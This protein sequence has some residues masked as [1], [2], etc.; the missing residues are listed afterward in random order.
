M[1]HG[2]VPDVELDRLYGE[3]DWGLAMMQMHDN[4]PRYNRFSFPCKFTM[5]LAS[6]LPLICL[7]HP[8]SGLM[9]LALKYKLG[10]MI[11]EP[12]PEKAAAALLAGLPR[13]EN[14]GGYRSEIVRCAETDFNAE[15]TRK[16]LY[17][18]F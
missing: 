3:C 7:G 9:E 2:F 16:R 1:E 11:T 15:K 10:I 6:G 18:L 17:E 12:D 4:D 13:T 5:A 8:Q 14:L